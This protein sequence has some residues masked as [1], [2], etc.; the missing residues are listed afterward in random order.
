MGYRA[1]GMQPLFV[2]V[3]DPVHEE[4]IKVQRDVYNALMERLKPGVTVGELATLTEEFCTKMKPTNGYAAGCTA[5]LNMHGRGQGDDG[6]LI[7][8]SQRR[9]EQ[10]SVQIKENMTFIF[11]P[12]VKSADG[13]YSCCWGDTIVITPKGGRRLG[14]RPHDLA[15]SAA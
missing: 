3:A 6:P 11:K 4:L 2:G 8:P 1:Q 13:E 7:T 14:K 9:P 15:V 10:L 12:Y 5:L